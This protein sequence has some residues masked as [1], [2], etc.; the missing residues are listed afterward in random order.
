MTRLGWRSS[1][2]NIKRTDLHLISS[3]YWHGYNDYNYRWACSITDTSSVVITGGGDVFNPTSRVTRYD[4]TGWV[5][6]LP[7][8]LTARANHGCALYTTDTG[9]KVLVQSREYWYYNIVTLRSMWSW[10]DM[11]VIRDSP[12]QKPSN[13]ENPLGDRAQLYHDHYLD[14]EQLHWI[15]SFTSQVRW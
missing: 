7:S 1:L 5:E 11:M 15:T 12:P 6:D 10:G 4:E 9:D 3:W 13:W 14:W 2:V 8:L